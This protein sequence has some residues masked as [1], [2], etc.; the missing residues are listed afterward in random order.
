MSALPIR[1]LVV[2]RLQEL[3]D[4]Q[5]AEC[6]ENGTSIRET[7]IARIGF[8]ALILPNDLKELS[9]ERDKKSLKC[10]EFIGNIQSQHIRNRLYVRKSK[11]RS[12]CHFHFLPSTQTVFA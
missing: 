4:E 10:S 9:D 11:R 5:V 12:P 3:S 1:E 6:Y 8:F 7:V 2:E